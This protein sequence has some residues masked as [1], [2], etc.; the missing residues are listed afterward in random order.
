DQ[1]AARIDAVQTPAGESRTVAGFLSQATRYGDDLLEDVEAWLRT[2]LDQTLGLAEPLYGRV[3]MPVLD[4]MVAALFNSDGRPTT[5][6]FFVRRDISVELRQARQ[7]VRTEL[8]QITA[9]RAKLQ[10]EV[11][12]SELRADLHALIRTAGA[13]PT[14]KPLALER[15][16]AS[17]GDLAQLLLEGQFS[18]IFKLERLKDEIETAILNLLP[19]KVGVV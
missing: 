11:A 3:A 16:V 15:A 14:T 5:L 2:V 12:Y 7:D 6:G 17:V 19:V 18:D 8:T 1:L 9:L 13:A 4:T 10:Q